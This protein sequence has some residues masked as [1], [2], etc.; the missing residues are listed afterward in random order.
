MLIAER[1]DLF[2]RLEQTLQVRA[3]HVT[4]IAVSP[5]HEY[6]SGME[7]L[8]SRVPMSHNTGE[9][10]LSN[11]RS[12]KVL[13][14]VKT[15]S[16]LKPATE[17]CVGCGAKTDDRAVEGPL[18][19]DRCYYEPDG[20]LLVKEAAYL[21]LDSGQTITY[22]KQRALLPGVRHGLHSMSDCA[23]LSNNSDRAA[24]NPS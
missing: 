4:R 14:L 2:G 10:R 9:S 20:G 5:V 7:C 12:P 19:E 13:V 6:V 11:L 23:V 3:S 17:F 16:L 8:D 21:G 24:R 15:M 18:E 22:E 1:P